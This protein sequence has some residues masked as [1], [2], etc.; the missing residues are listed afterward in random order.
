MDVFNKPINQKA[1]KHVKGG[2]EVNVDE[3]L[4]VADL[5]RLSDSGMVFQDIEPSANGRK[6]YKFKGRLKA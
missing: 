6:K 5:K 3:P 2:L 1:I 4:T